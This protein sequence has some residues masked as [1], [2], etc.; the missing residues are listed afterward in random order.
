MSD[1]GRFGPDPHD[2]FASIYAASVAPWDIGRPQP[3][4]V[5][6][7]AAYPPADPILDV[8]CGAGDHVIFLAQAG[9]HALGVDFVAAA[10]AQAQARRAELPP[11]VAAR[12]GFQVADALRPSKLGT[13]FGAIVDSGFLHV[14]E[15]EQGDSFIDDAALALQPG[16]RYYLLAFAVDFSIPNVPRQIT[17]QTV[18]THFSAEKGWQVLVCR[19]AEFLNRVAPTPAVC[20]VIERLPALG[21]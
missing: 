17:E 18:R 5:D 6:L 3:A 20:A 15:T 21:A 7:F 10:V 19:P 16:G 9:Y 8:G 1:D 12:A 2:F 4:L 13:K 14:L 11:A